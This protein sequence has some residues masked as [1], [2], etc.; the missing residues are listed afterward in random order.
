MLEQSRRIDP[1]PSWLRLEV[2]N[3]GSTLVPIHQSQHGTCLPFHGVLRGLHHEV[4]ISGW[5]IHQSKHGV[6]FPVAIVAVVI[7]TPLTVLVLTLTV[8]P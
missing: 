3:R 1:S 6:L 5:R 4:W 8:T 7:V 2:S